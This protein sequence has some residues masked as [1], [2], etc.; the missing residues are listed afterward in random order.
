MIQFLEL[1]TYDQYLYSPKSWL[2]SNK[3]NYK[4]FHSFLQLS[5]LPFM[6]ILYI[7]I[8]LGIC[9]L[10]FQ[11]I[12]IPN[13]VKNN[14]KNF[15][16]FLLTIMCISLYYTTQARLN[17]TNIINNAIIKFQPL[18]FFSSYVNSHNN[19][20]N[21]IL[22][23]SIYISLPMFRLLSI[24]IIYLFIIKIV[25]LTT[26]YEEII[27][28][29]IDKTQLAHKFLCS[30]KNFLI[31]MSSQFLKVI[32]LEI[33]K[34]KISYLIR[35]IKQNNYQQFI[36]YLILYSYLVKKFYNNLYKYVNCITYSLYSRSIN[37]QSLYFLNIYDSQK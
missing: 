8:I 11:F 37:S 19:L 30:E 26:Y 23:F 2:H 6:P 24:S 10:I 18:S 1:S 17:N 34:I 4:I 36:Q 12:N 35:G 3:Q 16:L 31:M 13:K 7:L 15:F 9:T 5:L 20:I 32:F 28:L 22:N 29:L 25:L 21:K 33:E 14:I 27:N